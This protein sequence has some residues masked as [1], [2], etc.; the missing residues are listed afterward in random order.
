MSK[1]PKCSQKKQTNKK[2]KKGNTGLIKTEILEIKPMPIPEG[3]FKYFKFSYRTKKEQKI[4][5]LT[6]KKDK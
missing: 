5:I 6:R 1:Q 2:K 4:R 3:I